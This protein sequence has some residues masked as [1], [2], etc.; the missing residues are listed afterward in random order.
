M[1]PCLLPRGFL[2]MSSRRY[3]NVYRRSGGNPG[4]TFRGTGFMNELPCN[5]LILKAIVDLVTP[6]T[7]VTPKWYVDP[8]DIFLLSSMFFSPKL[9]KVN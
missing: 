3:S 1:I 2:M 7:P 9:Q 4:N 6:V 5:A 8:L